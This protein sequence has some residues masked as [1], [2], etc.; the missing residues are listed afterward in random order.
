MPGESTAKN[1]DRI[2]LRGV[3]A[4]HIEHRCQFW[5][6]R[7]G[8]YRSSWPMCF[9]GTDWHRLVSNTTTL[10]LSQSLSSYLQSSA[11]S[12]PCLPSASMM[13]AFAPWSRTS[14]HDEDPPPRVPAL[15]LIICRN[16][17]CYNIGQ[18]LHL[19]S[20]GEPNLANRPGWND[21]VGSYLCNR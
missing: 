11:V 20:P 15:T 18:G 3:V 1:F 2:V 21:D 8:R 12:I 13:A 7:R 4:G 5:R 6:R 9:N 10:S 17:N 14:T 16:A 19:V